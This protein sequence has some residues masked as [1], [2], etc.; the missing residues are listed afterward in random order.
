MMIV[1]NILFGSLLILILLG[2]I[3]LFLTPYID[4][5]IRFARMGRLSIEELQ[6]K[7]PQL[8]REMPRHLLYLL[9]PEVLMFH[10]RMKLP[11][12]GE[13]DVF[14]YAPDHQKINS[15][16]VI[17]LTNGERWFHLMKSKYLNN[18]RMKHQKIEA[19]LYGKELYQVTPIPYQSHFL[20]DLFPVV[21]FDFGLSYDH[22][23]F[24]YFK[25]V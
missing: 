23:F 25:N 9:P 20:S 8:G 10:L 24:L 2:I 3:S 11:F 21:H 6:K 14:I 5:V 4:N 16:L 18:A 12:G 22:Q 17:P 13:S 19:T 15:I 1:I 7:Y